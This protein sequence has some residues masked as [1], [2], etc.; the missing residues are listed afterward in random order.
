[1]AD[2]TDAVVVYDPSDDTGTD[3]S[4]GTPAP[5]PAP[6]LIAEVNV[7]GRPS[8]YTSEM[9]AKI[10]KLIAE[11]DHSVRRLCREN[12][13]LPDRATINRW[14]GIYE[15]FRREF[16]A[17]ASGRIDDMAYECIDIVDACAA[18]DDILLGKTREQLNERHWLMG[19]LAPKRYGETVGG[20]ALDATALPP[21]PEAPRIEEAPRGALPAIE[22]SGDYAP[23]INHPLY[24][25]AAAWAAEGQRLKGPAA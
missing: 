23:G 22:A 9:G 18:G 10:C 12:D 1:M 19:K 3:N 24:R 5:P 20:S 17:A 6:K 8:T 13:E 7:G 11:S 21:P 2:S 15:D 4:P 16:I 14:L 25:P